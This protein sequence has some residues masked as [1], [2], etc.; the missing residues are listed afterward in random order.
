MGRLHFETEAEFL[1]HKAWEK[2]KLDLPVD[3]EK[4]AGSLGIEVHEKEF[5]DDIDGFYVHVI[6]TA[7]VI[8]IN[9]SYVKPLVRRRF[10]LAHEIGHHLFANRAVASKRLCF[11]DSTKTGRNM[12]ER[13]CDHFA[14]FFLCLRS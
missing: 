8:A 1:A 9:K 2:L 10:T 12:T 13:A 6:G 3:L 11:F 7:P 5:T 14:R 4:V